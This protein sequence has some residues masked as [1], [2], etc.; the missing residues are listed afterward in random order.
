MLSAIVLLA[1]ASAGDPA[2]ESVRAPAPG[3]TELLP[4]LAIPAASAVA[5]ATLGLV[6]LLFFGRDRS[7]RDL[8]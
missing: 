1:A 4:A 6:A 2:L 7:R 8:L 5:I 3:V